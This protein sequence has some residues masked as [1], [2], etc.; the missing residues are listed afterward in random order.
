M[1]GY[2]SW[3]KMVGLFVEEPSIDHED[4]LLEDEAQGPEYPR[5]SLD[6]VLDRPKREL[7]PERYERLA[8]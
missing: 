6:L 3:H 5:N 8:A 7:P 1:G 4:R 2:S